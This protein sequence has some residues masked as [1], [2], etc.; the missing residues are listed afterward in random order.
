[1]S[2]KD[3][4]SIIPTDT[5]HD[6][7]FAHRCVDCD[8]RLSTVVPVAG[9]CAEGSLCQDCFDARA[10]DNAENICLHNPDGVDLSKIPPGWELLTAAEAEARSHKLGAKNLR[11]WLPQKQH[12][13]SELYAIVVPRFTY[14]KPTTPLI[15]NPFTILAIY[16]ATWQYCTDNLQ[17]YP[18]FLS[19]VLKLPH[20]YLT[21]DIHHL[22]LLFNDRSFK[23]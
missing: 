14:I 15:T 1:M 19:F 11:F 23:P 9:D 2:F 10:D 22:H 7:H 20:A 8:T 5:Q 3:Q 6:E 4:N 12:F 13:H 16:N 21:A 18:E 17:G